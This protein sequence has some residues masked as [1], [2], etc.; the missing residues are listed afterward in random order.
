MSKEAPINNYQNFVSRLERRVELREQKIHDEMVSLPSQLGK[1]VIVVSNRIFK[2]S[3]YDSE[4]Q[5]QAFH[6]E[7][8]R[9]ADLR[10][11][12]YGGL[13]IRRSA[14][15][16]EI[17]DDLRDVEVSDMMFIGHGTIDEFWLDDNHSLGWRQVAKY[18]RYL[19]QGCIEQRMCGNFNHYSAVPMGT[20][21][22]VDQRD[23]IAPLGEAIDDVCPDEALFE[24]VYG[25]PSNS[26]RDILELIHYFDSYNSSSQEP[27]WQHG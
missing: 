11:G 7:A 12:Y 8:D 3:E 9:F 23:L 19:K 15:L 17:R 16:T 25:K 5:W 21:A 14:K 26:S 20:F 4:T 18:A 2:N 6:D 10:A 13:E 1:L 24:P 22:L 27:L